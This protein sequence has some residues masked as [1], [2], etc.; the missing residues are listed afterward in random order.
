[1]DMDEDICFSCKH[2]KTERT[3]KCPTDEVAVAAWLGL[4]PVVVCSC[5]EPEGGNIDER[6]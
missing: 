4:A 3:G 5:Y 2:L 6:N 1:M